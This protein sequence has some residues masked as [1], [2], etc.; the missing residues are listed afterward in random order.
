MKTP[1]FFALL[2]LVVSPLVVVH[3]LSPP[4]DSVHFSP[5]D[6]EQWERAHP[7]PAAKRLTDLN[8]GPPR[9]V[10]LIYFLPNDRPYRAE[11]VNRMKTTAR[12]VQTF[13][14]EQMQAHGHGDRTFRLETDAAGEPIVHRV[15]GQHP[16]SHYLN[17][18]FIGMYDELKQAFDL[19]RNNYIIVIDNSTSGIRSNMFNRL[20]GGEG[21]SGGKEGNS[22]R[23]SEEWLFF[24]DSGFKTMAH[25]LGHT[26]GLN[27]DFRNDEYIMSY[28][29]GGR[30][31]ACA[32]EFL[33]GHHYFNPDVPTGG[34]WTPPS[35]EPIS[36][37]YPAGSD[38]ASVQLRVR[39]PDG[40]HQVT[41]LVETR[42]PHFAA[43]D[44]EV[45]A[46][47]GLGGESEAVVEFDYDGVIPSDPL[48]TSF[49]MSSEHPIVIGAVDR[50]GNVGY[51]NFV[52]AEI[53]PHQIATLEG[54]GSRGYAVSMAFSPNGETLAAGSGKTIELWDVATKTNI[55]TLGPTGTISSVAFSPDGETLAT[56]A[57]NGVVRL[58]DVATKTNIT[59]PEAHKW[60]SISVAFSPNGE[61]LA[62]GSGNGA[63][64]LWDVATKTNIAT[65]EA[66]K[67]GDNVSSAAFSPSVAFSPDG[68]TLAAGALRDDASATVKLW[69]VAT[70]TNVATFGTAGAVYSVAFSPDGE[71]L[72]AGRRPTVQLWDVATKTSI[73]TFEPTGAGE[74]VRSV[75][76]SPDGASLATGRGYTI[77]LWDVATKTNIATF[78]A[79]GTVYSVAFSPDGA[80]LASGSID[81]IVQLWDVSK[82]TDSEEDDGEIA[83]GFSGAVEDQV[84]TAG[85]AISALQL[86][87]A[88]G[89]D[90]EV[91]YRVSDLP[92]G[93]AFD[94]ATRT[95]SGTPEAATDGAVEVTYTAQDS[96]G[97]AAAL[98]FSI[99]VHPP[100]NFSDLLDLFGAGGG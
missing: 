86:P 16:D 19:S 87:E 43:G 100:L 77:Q 85:S 28:G 37:R 60:K 90:G 7:R 89:G 14:A 20:V 35:I 66:Q 76:F 38:S 55:A 65:L 72:A 42:T 39:D 71:T 17:Y 74:S 22:A 99:E 78:G 59:I 56:G 44:Q 24:E 53:S 47:R 46:C 48:A 82:W 75:A 30:L 15:D 34:G 91:T 95:I 25:E 23:F 27:H 69:D 93:L 18:T 26:F 29:P 63:V 79:T 61:I 11:V 81:N 33:A 67:L 73:A 36:L 54:H 45:K 68:E 40:L 98:T 70:K 84:Y 41:L 96:A 97:A 32:A 92:A 13:Y 10:R 9:T 51:D 88:T 2:G 52:L 57:Q 83:F 21:E 31:S 94:A 1:A 80:I 3:A 12:Q 58:W 4:A 49:S 6:Y 5:V 62:T 8:V 64:K 50:D